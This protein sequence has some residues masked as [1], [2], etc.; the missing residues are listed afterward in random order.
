MSSNSKSKLMRKGGVCRTCNGK[1]KVMRAGKE[2]RC[3]DCGGKGYVG[4]LTK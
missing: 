1:G 4:Y 2:V 3:Q